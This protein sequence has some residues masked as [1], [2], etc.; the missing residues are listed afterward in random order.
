ML[1]PFKDI[2]DRD[3]ILFAEAGGKTLGFFPGLP[4]YNEALIHANGLR[5]PWDYLKLWWHMRS[6][7]AYLAV[8]SV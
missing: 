6:R 5:Y 7:P 2:A 1:L 3:L 8:K 4:N